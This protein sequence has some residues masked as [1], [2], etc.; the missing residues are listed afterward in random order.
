MSIIPQCE[1][2]DLDL[3]DQ[4]ATA[5]AIEEG[6]NKYREPTDDRPPLSS[7]RQG[8]GH[9]PLVSNQLNV[10]GMLWP[11]VAI[12]P[13]HK[14][15][16]DRSVAVSTDVFWNEDMTTC[17]RGVKVQLLGRGGVAV[18]GL[19]DGARDHGKDIFFTAWAP[20]PRRRPA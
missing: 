3:N 9:N 13:A 10:F 14:L 20:V 11:E 15:N 1:T 18:Y 4:R 5:R 17:P 16:N 2:S 6:W 12:R 19:Y 8:M 7:P